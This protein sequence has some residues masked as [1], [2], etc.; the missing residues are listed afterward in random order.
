[1]ERIFVAPGIK[2][3][4]CETAG[5]DRAWLRKVRPY[6]G[7]NDHMH[8]RLACPAGTPCRGQAAPP[9]GDGCGADLDYW[10]TAAPYTPAPPPK[11]PPKPVT[12]ADLPPACRSVAAAESR[13]GAMTMLQAFAAGPT[14]LASASP[15]AA[16]IEQVVGA[17]AGEPAR[18]P[19]P[20]PEGK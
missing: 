1:V 16:A 18:L 8:V 20:R 2:K 15:A 9:P 10:F 5:E 4:L 13:P 3:K 14:A 11:K 19:Q 17:G 6:Y 12:L 7:H